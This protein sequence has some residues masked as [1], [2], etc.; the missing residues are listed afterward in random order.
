MKEKKIEDFLGVLTIFVMVLTVFAVVAIYSG[1]KDI[2]T[3][4]NYRNTINVSGEGEVFVKPD[5]GMVTFS[6][7]NEDESAQKALTENTSKTN[8][9]FNYLKEKGIEEK[10]IKTTS[11]NI[12]PRYE[13][14]EKDMYGSGKRVLAGYQA[15][16]A[17]E[18]KIREIDVMGEIIEGGVTSGANEVYGVR[19]VVEDEEQYMEE[20]RE[21]AI[22]NAKDKADKLAGQLGVRLVQIVNYNESGSPIMYR[23]E[24]AYDAVGTGGSYPSTSVQVGENSIKSTVSISCEIK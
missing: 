11:F 14:I 9:L 5:L 22:N 6:V 4:P 8:Q 3:H 13:Y 7:T 2:D 16:Q 1:I 12:S 21:M 15:T 17:V 10:D 24:M 18:V 23:E 20:V 19:F